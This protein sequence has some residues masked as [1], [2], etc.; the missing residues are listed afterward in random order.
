MRKKSFERLVFENHIN[1]LDFQLKLI[2]FAKMLRDKKDMIEFHELFDLDELEKETKEE[3]ERT[4]NY[5]K[6]IR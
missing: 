5:V 2:Q 1:S 4:K 3:I 6:R